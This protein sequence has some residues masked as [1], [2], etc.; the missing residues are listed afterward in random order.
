MF[1][2]ILNMRM[3]IV[4]NNKDK[5]IIPIKHKINVYLFSGFSIDCSVFVK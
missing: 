3:K 5:M 4:R 2:S 1:F